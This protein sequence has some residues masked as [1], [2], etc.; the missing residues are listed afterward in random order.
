MT[1]GVWLGKRE[2]N[3]RRIR[4]KVNEGTRE[5]FRPLARS[6]KLKLR[7]SLECCW[8]DVMNYVRDRG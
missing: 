3:R 2:A 1:T 4:D 7:W 8:V 6:C 5:A